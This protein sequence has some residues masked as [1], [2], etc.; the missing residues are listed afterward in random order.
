MLGIVA[1]AAAA[2]GHRREVWSSSVRARS[3]RDRNVGGANAHSQPAPGASLM[4]WHPVRLA[5][6]RERMRPTLAELLHPP[7]T[8][9]VPLLFVLMGIQVHLG[10]LAD[11]TV[12]RFGTVL[13][14][15]AVAGKLACGLGVVGPGINRL[16]VAVGMIP[17]PH[18]AS[19]EG[20]AH[21]RGDRQHASGRRVLQSQ[22]QV[23]LQCA[24][25]SG[26]PRVGAG[27]RCPSGT[28]SSRCPW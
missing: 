13:V 20:T 26:R 21:A 10:S 4:S 14:L 28:G 19:A 17:R 2:E 25:F 15:C 9:F 24:L 8:L 5:S 11:A 12:L 22:T 18:A 23:P 16:A 6:V 7:S 27:S 3:A 1:W